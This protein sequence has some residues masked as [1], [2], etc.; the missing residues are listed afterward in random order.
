MM[1]H[2]LSGV[3]AGG[4]FSP[5]RAKTQGPSEPDNIAHFFMAI[6]PRAFRTDTEFEDDLDQIIDIL[7]GT[8]PADPRNPV[9]VAGDKE[10]AERERRLAN[11]IPFPRSLIDSAKAIAEDCNASFLLA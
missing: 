7:H 10:R 1:A 3:L 5:I 11:G 4:S 9:L 2:I 6:D 8:R